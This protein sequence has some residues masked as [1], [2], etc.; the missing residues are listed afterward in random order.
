MVA[1]RW[2]DG[3]VCPHCGSKNVRFLEKYERWYCREKHHAPQFTLKTGTI[4]E[5]SPIPLGK[6]LT[7]MWMIVNCKNGISSYEIHRDIGVTQKSAWFML[8]RIREALRP[9]GFDNR[10]KLGGPGDE[11]EV[12][13]SFIGRAQMSFRVQSQFPLASA[14][15][16]S[17]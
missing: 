12:D 13:E 7:A 6:W 17:I 8:H 9:H 4:F 1:R 3:V 2:P 16:P 10:T 5:D 15:T 14:N 11:V